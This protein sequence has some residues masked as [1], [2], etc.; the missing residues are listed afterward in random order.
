M[1]RLSGLVALVT[2]IC[3][4][5]NPINDRWIDAKLA[6]NRERCQITLRP[7]GSNRG[8]IGDRIIELQ[9]R[10]GIDQKSDCIDPIAGFGRTMLHDRNRQHACVRACLKLLIQHS[11]RGRRRRGN[12]ILTGIGLSRRRLHQQS[13][14]QDYAYPPKLRIA[15]CPT[16]EGRIDRGDWRA[17]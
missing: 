6:Q 3:P 8:Q 14:Q 2:V 12:V 16:E 5:S 4:G 13:G 9:N 17:A 11:G 10:T 7:L 1:A 15:V